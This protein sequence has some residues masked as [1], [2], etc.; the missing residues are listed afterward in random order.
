MGM[1]NSENTCN[2]YVATYYRNNY[3]SALQAYAL[4]KR[5]E[6]LGA[7]ASVV[8]L[9]E[10][11][12]RCCL[13]RLIRQFYYALKP[14]VNYNI[15]YRMK[16]VLDQGKLRS[17]KD[18]IN[19]FVDKNLRIISVDECKKKVE[20]NPKAVLL[21]GS[22]QIWNLVNSNTINGCYLFDFIQGKNN[23][24]FSYAVSVGLKEFTNDQIQYYKRALSD[25]RCISI[26]EKNAADMFAQMFHETPVRNDVD[27]TFLHGRQFWE[28]VASKRMH[29]KEYVFVYELRP[30]KKVIQIAR[31]I[32]KEKKLDIVYIG[33][34]ATRHI[35]VRDVLDAGVEDFLS[36]IKEASA[37]VT[38]SFHG[39]VFSFIFEKPFVSVRISTTSSRVENLLKLTNLESQ[40]IDSV[41]GY[42]MIDKEI[43]F[44]NAKKLLA[45]KITSSENYLMSICNQSAYY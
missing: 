4:Q 30:D 19:E 23:L 34:F 37:V 35:G 45:D 13:G 5:I 1:N 40:L 27:P 32:A 33:Q 12:K 8:G 18:K 43:S 31:K 24:K 6:Q 3:G 17:R 11:K 36:Y 42:S 9:N 28:K 22:D 10:Q 41:D 29:N 38:N 39:T 25:F 44:E 7:K 20:S 16:R 15:F 2:V 21:A 26:R 14:E